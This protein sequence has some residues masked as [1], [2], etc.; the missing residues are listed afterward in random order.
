VIREHFCSAAVELQVEEVDVDGAF[1][2]NVEEHPDEPKYNRTTMRT[3][4]L[5]RHNNNNL[6]NLRKLLSANKI[7][8]RETSLF[9]DAKPTQQAYAIAKLLVSIRSQ[10]RIMDRRYSAEVRLH[11][12]MMVIYLFDY[13]IQKAME[14]IIFNYLFA[15]IYPCKNKEETCILTRSKPMS[16]MMEKK[17]TKKSQH[18]RAMYS[19]MT[20]PSG[21]K[22]IIANEN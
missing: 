1:V 12:V 6:F 11:Y 17:M 9:T 22:L 18:A 21:V 2:E 10:V 13:R 3:I 7:E 5:Q 8:V 14:L 20:I 16:R 15:Q 4:R 19:F